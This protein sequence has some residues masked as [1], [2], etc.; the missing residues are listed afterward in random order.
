MTAEIELPPGFVLCPKGGRPPKV[1]RDMA[2]FLALIWFEHKG[3][4]T[5][6]AAEWIMK[7]F[8]FGERSEVRRARR[9][10]EKLWSCKNWGVFSTE[11]LVVCVEMAGSG[12]SQN[13]L[14][15][16]WAWRE[17]MTEAAE[18]MPSAV[19]F[20]PHPD[21]ERDLMEVRLPDMPSG[22]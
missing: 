11:N 16:G 8:N 10:A 1:A 12:I 9:N 3:V 17:E 15:R 13:P 21:S 19:K 14:A 18:I 7:K 4:H 20:Y 22:Q 2:V 5:K 6:K